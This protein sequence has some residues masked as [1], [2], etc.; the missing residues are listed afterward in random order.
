MVQSAPNVRINFY[1]F[2]PGTG[3][4]SVIECVLNR[5]GTCISISE[6]QN[7]I[8]HPDWTLAAHCPPGPCPHRVALTRTRKRSRSL[9][10]QALPL[11]CCAAGGCPART[12]PGPPPPL[13]GH[14]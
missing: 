1:R 6:L 10:A 13:Q 2:F 9:G 3:N 12:W 14:L 7:V 8:S 4:I 11:V 5:F